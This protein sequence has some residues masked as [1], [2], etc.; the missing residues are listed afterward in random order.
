M[1]YIR[2]ASSYAEVGLDTARKTLR[3]GITEIE[4]AAAVEGSLRAAGSDYWAVPTEI[5][6]G[7]NLGNLYL[8]MGNAKG[9]FDTFGQVAARCRQGRGSQFLRCRMGRCGQGLQQCNTFFIERRV[10]RQRERSP[11]EH[12]RALRTTH[13]GSHILI[14][15]GL[16]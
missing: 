10:Q 7:L 13:D 8:A 12:P 2:E 1:A 3:A 15:K 11:V 14:R 5:A 6:S 9:A 16:L 4:L